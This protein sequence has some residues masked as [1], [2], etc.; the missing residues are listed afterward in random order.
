MIWVL[1]IG[2][3]ALSLWAAARVKS[4]YHRCNQRPVRSGLTGAQIAADILRGK[5]IW[6]V[7]IAQGE[8]ML[9]DHYHPLHKRLGHSTQP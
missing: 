1:F 8:G 7:E 3:L 5:G 4:V 2:T 9:G 6:G